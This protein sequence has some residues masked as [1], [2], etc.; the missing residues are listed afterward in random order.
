MCCDDAVGEVR[1][2]SG[3]RASRACRARRTRRRRCARRNRPRARWLSSI[4]AACISMASPAAWPS[5]SL[6]CLKRSRSMCSS[7]SRAPPS[8]RS[9]GAVRVQDLVEIAP[10][11][12][13]GQRIVQRIVLDARLGRFQLARCAL[14]SASWPASGSRCS[15]TSAVTSQFGADRSWRLA[16]L[17]GRPGA[18]ARMCAISPSGSTTRYSRRIAAPAARARSRNRLGRAPD[19]R[20]GCARCPVAVVARPAVGRLAVELVHAVVPDQLVGRRCHIPT[21]RS[22]RLSS[23]SARRR[24]RRCSS[25]SR[26]RSSPICAAAPRSAGRR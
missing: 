22:A 14:R 19:R 8:L 26:R 25:V 5:V 4:S 16:G 20:D 9:L 23:A 17:A 7:A 2:A 10:V 12:Q 13:A 21:R 1:R 24:D 18:L 3:R 11:G 6:I 15:A